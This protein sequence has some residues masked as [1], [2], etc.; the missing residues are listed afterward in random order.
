MHLDSVLQFRKLEPKRK[1]RYTYL[2]FDRGQ[3]NDL[4]DKRAAVYNLD[5]AFLIVPINES[6]YTS[7]S[8]KECLRAVSL[9]IERHLGVHTEDLDKLEQE[10]EL[11]QERTSVKLRSEERPRMSGRSKPPSV[12]CG[13]RLSRQTRAGT[14]LPTSP[15]LTCTRRDSP[16]QRHPRIDARRVSVSKDGARPEGLDRLI[17]PRGAYRFCAIAMTLAIRT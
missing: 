13:I 9:Q 3:H 5:G 4:I 10:S 11:D 2:R 6:V 16:F 7:E 8:E 14:G 1:Y 12:L 15:V 17:A